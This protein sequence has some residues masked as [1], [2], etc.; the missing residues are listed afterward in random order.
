MSEWKQAVIAT[1]V[2]AIFTVL[3]R[4]IDRWLPD[5]EGRYPVAPYPSTHPAAQ[6]PASPAAPST[7]EPPTGL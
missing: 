6:P 3:A 2:G 4:F 7:S 1:A 5:P